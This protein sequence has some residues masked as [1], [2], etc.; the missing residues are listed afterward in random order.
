MWTSFFSILPFEVGFF[1]G[2]RYPIHYVGNPTVD[3]VTAFKASHQESFADFIADSELADK[4]II[5]LLAGSRKQEIKDNLPDMIRAASAFLYR[6]CAGSC[7]GHFSGILCQICK[8]N[9]TGGDF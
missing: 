7:S 4:P 5:A 1:K 3:E 2:H 9:G 6:A 8:R